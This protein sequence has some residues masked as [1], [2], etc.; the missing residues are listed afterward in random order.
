MG[1]PIKNESDI[2][3]VTIV[4]YN[5]E[6][7]KNNGTK[8]IGWVTPTSDTNEIISRMLMKINATIHS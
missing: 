7:R 4:F 8:E 5:D 2:Q 1:T 6:N 3:R